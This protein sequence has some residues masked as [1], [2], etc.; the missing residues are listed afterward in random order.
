VATSRIGGQLILLALGKSVMRLLQFST[1]PVLALQGMTRDER[2]SGR[3]VT[4]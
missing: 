2:I 4:V 3:H 1:N